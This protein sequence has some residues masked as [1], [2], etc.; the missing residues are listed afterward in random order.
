MYCISKCKSNATWTEISIAGKLWWH[1]II[2]GDGIA[3]HK[4]TL[5]GYDGQHVVPMVVYQMADTVKNLVFGT[6]LSIIKKRTKNA[7]CISFDQFLVSHSANLPFPQD[8]L[9]VNVSACVPANPS[10]HIVPVSPAILWPKN[11]R[12]AGAELRRRPGLLMHETIA[13]L[14]VVTVAL[15][16]LRR[17][18]LKIMGNIYGCTTAFMVERWLF[19]WSTYA[20]RKHH[21]WWLVVLYCYFCRNFCHSRSRGRVAGYSSQLNYYLIARG[22]SDQIEIFQ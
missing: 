8:Q 10:K 4:R 1:R 17:R 9:V 7:Q 14:A 11:H 5:L 22:A 3:Q 19:N 20:Y 16:L 12:H 2:P 6:H 21:V 13:P 15:R 18:V